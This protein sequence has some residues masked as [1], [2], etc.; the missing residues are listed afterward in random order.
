MRLLDISLD[1]SDTGKVGRQ[2]L[3]GAVNAE[4]AARFL[5]DHPTVKIVVVIDMHCVENGSFV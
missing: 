5:A 2:G 1:G 4:V 3:P